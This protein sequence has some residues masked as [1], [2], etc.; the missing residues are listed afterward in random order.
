[1]QWSHE[2]LELKRTTQRIVE[3]H[4]N[5]HV[6]AW[7]EAGR[8]PAHKVMKILGDAGLLGI[9][10]PEEFG[11]LALDYSYEI[12]CVEELGHIQAYG[13]SSE[14]AFRQLCVHPL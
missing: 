14:S 8:F 11:G 2:H 13:V 9:S 12:A 6:D 1:M 10:R 3:E 4:I 5:P 7:E